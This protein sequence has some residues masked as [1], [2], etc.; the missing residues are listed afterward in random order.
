MSKNNFNHNMFSKNLND[1]YF[2]I[3]EQKRID[4]DVRCQI[5][6]NVNDETVKVYLIKKNK[7]IKILTFKEGKKYYK[8]IGGK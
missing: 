5:E 4:L 7:I 1:A 8:S 3:I 2:E 6:T